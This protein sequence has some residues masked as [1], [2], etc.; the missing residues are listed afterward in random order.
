MNSDESGLL[1]L[2]VDSVGL[3]FK[4]GAMLATGKVGGLNRGDVFSGKGFNCE[5]LSGGASS[6]V[7]MESAAFLL[8]F[9]L[10]MVVF[11]LMYPV[12]REK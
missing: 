11:V 1:E 2:V 9:F 10:A 8:F 12:R 7:V 5:G 3:K 6:V 4:L